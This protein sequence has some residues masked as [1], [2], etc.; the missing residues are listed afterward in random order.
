M[1]ECYVCW[2]DPE[3]EDGIL[4]VKEQEYFDEIETEE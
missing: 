4:L 2:S 1:P 3:S